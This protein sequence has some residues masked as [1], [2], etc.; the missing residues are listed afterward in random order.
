MNKLITLC[1]V[2]MALAMTDLSAATATQNKAF[3]AEKKATALSIAATKKAVAAVSKANT[4]CAK[5]QT[6][7]AALPQG[8]TVKTPAE[9]IYARNQAAQD[10][11][12]AFWAMITMTDEEIAAA[13]AL[14]TVSDMATTALEKADYN[15]LTSAEKTAYKAS[16]AA[17]IGCEV[18]VDAV[19]LAIEKADYANMSIAERI[20]Y[21]DQ[22]AADQA[23][24]EQQ[25]ALLTPAQL[26]A[27]K[28]AI[29]AELYAEMGPY[30][31]DGMALA[32]E[33]RLL[34][35]ATEAALDPDPANADAIVIADGARFQ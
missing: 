14:W 32:P 34:M 19:K 22:Q 20:A 35:V 1:S 24:L 29:L 11:Y 2:A 7:L 30:Y 33:D 9:F 16:L 3:A 31:L 26:K 21:N 12:D 6:L 4:L 15:A 27:A 5:A 10:K 23:N 25:A 28:V 13:R 17:A 8:S 18:A